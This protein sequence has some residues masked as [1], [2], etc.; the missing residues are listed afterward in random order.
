[1]SRQDCKCH[2]HGGERTDS[3][4]TEEDSSLESEEELNRE[5]EEDEQEEDEKVEEREEE[6]RRRWKRGSC[7]YTRQ[8]HDRAITVPCSSHPSCQALA[9]GRHPQRSIA[10]ARWCVLCNME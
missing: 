9:R 5:D 7:S 6:G 3:D 4:G 10:K 8:G 2:Q 1:M